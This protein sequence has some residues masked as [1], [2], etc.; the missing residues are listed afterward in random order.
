[1][2]ERFAGRIHVLQGKVR[3]MLQDIPTNIS[4]PKHTYKGSF[5]ILFIYLFIYGL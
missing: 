5:L 2:A 1:M 3:I 4:L